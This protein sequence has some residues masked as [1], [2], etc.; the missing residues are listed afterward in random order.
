MKLNRIALAVVLAAPLALSAHAAVTVTPLLGMY[1]ADSSANIDDGV[2]AGLAAGLQFTP[3][4]GLEAEYGQS[5]DTK[6]FG[7]H[8]VVSPFS[9]RSGAFSPFVLTGFSQSKIDVGGASSKDTTVDLGGGVFYTLTD[10][11]NLRGELRAVYN[12]DH[13]LTNYLAVAGLQYTFGARDDEEVYEEEAPVK[14]PIT[15]APS[16]TDGDGVVDANDRCP[17]TPAG[18]E[19]GVDGC[20]LDADKDKV[21]NSIDECPNTPM[22]Q[23]VGANGCPMDD[24]KDGVINVNDKCPATPANEVVDDKGCTKT[25]TIATTEKVEE[26]INIVF[27]SGKAVIKPEFEKEV[28]KIADLAKA[29][30][31]AFITIEGHTDSS[32]NPARN[33][34][35]SQQRAEAVRS[36]LVQRF[37]VDA[38][39]VSAVGYGSAKPVADNTTADGKAKNRRVIAVLTAEKQVMEVK[40]MTKPAKK[41]VKGK[42][43]GKKAAK[44]K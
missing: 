8:A 11:L 33:K 28:A 23:P 37:S 5:G 14:R 9:W 10:N 16:D 42:K 22:G 1:S 31:N 40:K 24:D 21:P 12:S 2:Y 18:W 29:N 25:V 15:V 3:A 41:A 7:G 43:K 39:R 27:D 19:V 38:A 35:L 4:F 26:K 6:L 44:K 30:P 32:G 20:P 17:N 13:S 34:L 36:M